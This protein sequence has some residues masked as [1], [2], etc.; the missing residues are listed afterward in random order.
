[1]RAEQMPRADGIKLTEIADAV[2][3]AVM[4]GDRNMQTCLG[5]LPPPPPPA[6]W[7]PRDTTDRW[8]KRYPSMMSD[9]DALALS[10]ISSLIPDDAI[11]VEVGSRLGGSAKNI[12][13]HAPK[14]RRLYCIDPEWGSTD[15]SGLADPMMDRLR[16]TWQ[17]HHYASC[18]QFAEQLL[19]PHT[20]VRLL[21]MASPYDLS[22]WTEHVDFFFEDATHLNP[23]L[24]D[25]FDF[26]L[27]KI[28][29]GGM[30]AGH[31]YAAQWAEVVREVDQLRDRLGTELHVQGTV[32]WMR[33]P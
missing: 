29:Q 18:R 32:W 24:R 4:Q 23:V 11:A 15:G 5:E 7:Q 17:L 12:L 9:T 28:R 1:M 20:N 3:L 21:S 33:K 30:I 19:A 8:T 31:D 14:L 10:H 27:P 6:P 22:W 16:D 25:N 13:D 2:A 26:W